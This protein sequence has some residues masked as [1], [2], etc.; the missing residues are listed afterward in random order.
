MSGGGG[1]G[2]AWDKVTGGASDLWDRAKDDPLGM[3]LNVG[4][5][6][7]T[8]GL[9]PARD[10]AVSVR[11]NMR[12]AAA[13]KAQAEIDK[14]NEATAAARADAVNRAEKTVDPLALER[15][16]RASITT[17][18]RSGSILT[19]GTSL[20]SADIATKTLLGM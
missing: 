17:G 14:A 4:A 20:G 15:R 5:P 7:L 6:L 3:A 16:R 9:L 1:G 19:A 13:G 12:D 18:G 10:A 2:G 11:D 8:A